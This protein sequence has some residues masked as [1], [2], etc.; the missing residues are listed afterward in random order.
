[1]S[2]FEM[3]AHLSTVNARWTPDRAQPI[4]SKDHIEGLA[5][6]LIVIECFDSKHARM[7]STE[8]GARTGLPR[9]AAMASC[10]G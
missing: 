1:M 5:R 7:T 8:V 4:D 10:S 2:A 9:T 3:Q 6:G